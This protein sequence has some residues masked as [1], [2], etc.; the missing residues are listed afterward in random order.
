MEV[1][2][3][4]DHPFTLSA[5]NSLALTYKQN[6]QFDR[7]LPLFE[8]L[9]RRAKP[10]DAHPMTFVIAFN[11]G[12]NYCDAKRLKE[13]VAVF[14]EW[15]PRAAAALMPGQHPLP[16]G[17][18]LA[19][20]TY[21]RARQD[22]KAI[23]LLSQEV[24]AVRKES[25]PGDPR[26]AG[27]LTSLGLGL[28]AAGR[29]AEAEPPLR[30]SL[31]ILEGQQRDSWRTFAAR[32]VFG[33]SLLGQKKYAE[34]EPELLRGYE[35]LKQREAKIPANERACLREALQGLVKLYDA[36]GK[37]AEAGRWR[38]ELRVLKKP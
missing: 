12:D 31:A 24:A 35:G 14:D 9:L 37:R 1:T 21:F 29:H 6:R 7:S 11:L 13:A 19:A 17:R 3:G 30:E 16:V 32:A 4:D 25:K 5:R 28:I 27:A 22:D 34:A 8:D 33:A 36:W 23:A 20:K 38:A 15:L 2:L 26:L 18:R 10:S